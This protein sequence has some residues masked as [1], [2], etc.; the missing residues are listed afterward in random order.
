MFN[1]FDSGSLL[2][3]LG[4]KLIIN[5]PFSYSQTVNAMCIV[6]FVTHVVVVVFKCPDSWD[7]IPE[8][9][10]GASCSEKGVSGSKGDY[11]RTI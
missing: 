8:S 1:V 4:W 9:C 6:L 7:S 2:A 11:F 3:I 10:S 5:S